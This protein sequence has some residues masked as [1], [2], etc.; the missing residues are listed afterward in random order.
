MDYEREIISMVKQ[1]H[2]QSFIK[3]IETKVLINNPPVSRS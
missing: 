3:I 2:S 1:I